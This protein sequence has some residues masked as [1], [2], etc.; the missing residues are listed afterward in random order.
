MWASLTWRRP[1]STAMRACCCSLACG[2]RCSPVTQPVVRIQ[3]LPVLYM[4][5]VIRAAIFDLLTSQCDRHAQNIFVNEHGQ[6]KLID[7]EAALQSNWKNCAVN[8]ILVPTTQVRTLRF[9][10]QGMCCAQHALVTLAWVLALHA[11]RQRLQPLRYCDELWRIM[12]RRSKRLC[13]QA[14]SS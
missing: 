3:M 11:K 8:S 2:Q 10:A 7:N 14:T 9:T 13:G 4:V 1:I 6:I 12:C 5:Q